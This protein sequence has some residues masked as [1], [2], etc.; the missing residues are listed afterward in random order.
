MI[1]Q[2]PFIWALVSVPLLTLVAWSQQAPLPD[3]SPDQFAQALPEAS[4]E[5][6]PEA[7]AMTSDTH[8]QRATGQPRKCPAPK[9]SNL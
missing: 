7:Q 9:Q 2:S 6:S 1:H 5:T 8:A 3:P 4:P